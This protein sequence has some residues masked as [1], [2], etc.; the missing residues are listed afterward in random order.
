LLRLYFLILVLAGL[1]SCQK[2]PLEPCDTAQ[3]LFSHYSF[4]VGVA[5]NPAELYPNSAYQRLATQ[6]FNS[7]TPENIFKPRYL[8]P[9]PER[10]EWAEADQLAAFARANNQ[11]LHGHTL[12]WHQQLPG[13]M[14][15]FSGNADAWEALFRDHIQT[16]C[17]H[18]RGQVTSWDV[19]NEAFDADGGLRSTIWSQ[20]LGGS[21]LEKAFRYAHEADP[22]ALLFYNDYD[23]ESNPA[24]RQAVLAWLRTMRQR[25]VP[26]HGLG[27]QM[28]I[29]IAHPDNAQLAEALRE[30]QKTGLQ[31][32][33]SEIDVSVN[34]LGQVI[35]PTPALLQRQAEKLA[36]LVRTYRELPRAQQFGITFWGVSDRN[37][38][39][40]RYFQR[41]DYPLLFDDNYQPKPAFCILARP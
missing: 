38:W 35:A 31:L 30:A 23:L 40:R 28:H 25:G 22:D 2:A 36:F 13:W 17:R 12:I 7:I 20:H 6:H 8:H 24:K 34:P 32:H 39:M 26:V 15:S 37:T 16:I 19:V 4:P 33:L 21:Y 9:A 11:R 3:A 1:S 27:L 18:F 14:T 10:Y 41:D 29:S 5:I